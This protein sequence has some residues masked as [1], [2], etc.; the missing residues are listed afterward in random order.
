MI[1]QLM[2]TRKISRKRL[3]KML[4]VS[5]VTVSNWCSNNYMPTK[6]KCDKMCA[7]FD[8]SY[9]ELFTDLSGSTME[10]HLKVNELDEDQIR[11]VLDFIYEIQQ[12]EILRKR[13]EWQKDS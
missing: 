11:K 3:A 1:K 9:Y 7:I 13:F 4:G 8:C 2:E 5:E 12:A 6:D 10:L